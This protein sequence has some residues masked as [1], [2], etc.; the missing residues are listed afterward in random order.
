M[1]DAVPWR[2]SQDR[3]LTRHNERNEGV[4]R[5]EMTPLGVRPNFVAGQS[6]CLMLSR[7]AAARLVSGRNPVRAL[8]GTPKRS[9]SVSLPVRQTRSKPVW[10]CRPLRQFLRSR[11]RAFGPPQDDES[12]PGSLHLRKSRP[13]QGLARFGPF[14]MRRIFARAKR[15]AGELDVAGANDDSPLRSGRGAMLTLV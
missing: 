8:G 2:L 12:A 1:G 15:L 13:L 4:V 5:R 14:S 9:S 3:T 6:S 11:S 10:A 7:D